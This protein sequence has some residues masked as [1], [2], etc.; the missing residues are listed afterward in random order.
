MIACARPQSSTW[1]SGRRAVVRR[2]QLLGD[3]CA[4]PQSSTWRSAGGLWSAGSNCWV[5]ARAGLW[6]STWRSSRR[7]VVH[8]EQLLGDCSCW[9]TVQHLAHSGRWTV[10]R[11]ELLLV[12]A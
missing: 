1:R 12:H 9:T 7:T 6:S 8:R 4:G 2:E 3:A 10:V 5:I 11:R